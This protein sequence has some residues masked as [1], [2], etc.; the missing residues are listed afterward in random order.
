MI[1]KEREWYTVPAPGQRERR[2]REAAR[3]RERQGRQ[4]SAVDRPAR[5]QC[6]VVQVER[7]RAREA[8]GSGCV[9]FCKRAGLPCGE[10]F[11]DFAA[12]LVEGVCVCV[13]HLTSPELWPVRAERFVKIT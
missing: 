11:S 3:E 2:E 4:R 1:G 6:A 13:C 12:A 7:E 9:A 5:R 10:G 8:R